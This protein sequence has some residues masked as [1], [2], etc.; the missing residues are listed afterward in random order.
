[1]LER[2]LDTLFIFAH[3]LLLL[4]PAPG[5]A[6]SDFTDAGSTPACTV[7]PMLEGQDKFMEGLSKHEIQHIV[8]AYRPTVV[9]SCDML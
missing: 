9:S 4:L 3:A 7:R 1:M 2:M 5:W 6:D 8:G